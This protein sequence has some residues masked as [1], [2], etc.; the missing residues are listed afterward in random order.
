MS[1]YRKT[2]SEAMAEVEK[3]SEAGYLE[4]KM[5]PR[6]IQNI[7]RIWQFKTK[8][9]VTPAVIKMI[10]NM[11]PVTQGAIKDAGINLLSDIAEGRMSEIDAMRKAGASAAEI[12]KELKL[13]V[14]TVKAILGE[15]DGDS[16]QD[17]QD[18]KPPREKI[19]ENVEQ[20]AE[21]AKK[22]DKKKDDVAPDNDVP[23]EV[24]EEEEPAKEVEKLKKELEKSREQTVAVKQKAQTDA[25]KQAQR[26]RTAQ[27]KMVN[28]QTG[29]PLLQVGIAYKHLKQKMEKEKKEEEQKQRSDEIAKLGA[30]K[31]KLKEDELDMQDMTESAAGD[32]AKAMGLDYMKFGRYG[33]DG[34]VTHKSKGDSLVAVGKGDEPKSDKPKSKKPKAGKKSKPKEADDVKV[35]ARNFLRDLD[36]GNL[37]NED[38]D[39]IEIDFDDEFSFDPIIDKAREMGLDDEFMDDLED[40]GS[41]VAEMEPNK[42]Q[43]AFRDMIAKY[44]GKPA[45]DI[46]KMKIADKQME[47]FNKQEYS[48]NNLDQLANDLLPLGKTLV[49]MA[50]ANEVE[51]VRGS[52]MQNSMRGFKDEVLSTIQS[53][54]Q[55]SSVLMDVASEVNDEEI[56]RKL[57]DIAFEFEYCWDENGDHDSYTKSDSVTAGLEMAFDGIKDLQKLVKKKGNSPDTRKPKK[58]IGDMI[59][60]SFDYNDPSSIEDAIEFARESGES[61]V[62]EDLESIMAQ[63]EDDTPKNEIQMEIQDKVAELTN[64]PLKVKKNI[65]EFDKMSDMILDKI[66]G[67]GYDYEKQGNKVF[68]ELGN[69]IR[70]WGVEFRDMAASDPTKGSPGSSAG[71]G[72]KAFRPDVIESMTMYSDIFSEENDNFSSLLDNIKNK[73]RRDQLKDR[74]EELNQYAAYF[75]E[76]DGDE[77]EYKKEQVM[78]S[79]EDMQELISKIQSGL[80]LVSLNDNSEK[81]ESRLDYVGRILQEKKHRREDLN[82]D[83]EKTIKPI[84]K[85][86]KKS[87]S[88]HDK[89]AKSLEKAMKNEMK[90]D[91]AY[92]IGMAQAKKVMND[93]PPLQKKTIKKGHEIADKILKKEENLQE[94]LSSSQIAILKREYEPFRGKTI[95]AARARQLMNILDKFKE[96]DLKKLAKANIPFVSSGSESKLAVRKMGYKV[97]T[98][99]PMGSF[100]E[101]VSE[102]DIDEACWTGYKQVG[103]K[104]KGN[105]QVPNCVPE[106]IDPFMI[107][108]SKHGKHAGFEGGKT[109]QDIQKKAQELRKK[110]FTID[111]MG[112]NNPPVKKE[113]APSEA[114]I[115]RLKKQG[116]KPRKEQKD[117]PAAAVY[118]SIAAVKKKA[119]KSGM[120]YGV[121][122]KVYDRGMAAWRGG[123]RPGATQVQ[124]ALARVN[125][126]VTKSS[127]T[128]GGADKD[129]AKQVKGK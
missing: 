42:A 30:D 112:R 99:R 7:K 109:L 12:A 95:N 96:A 58:K 126:F 8:K 60:N 121:L 69:D 118:E 91:D 113:N 28:P 83:D 10:K 15:S 87:V 75:S 120:P 73:K 46:E 93:E 66:E 76:R 36:K 33:K 102:K 64:K 71:S 55:I 54:E 105:K 128:W 51:G 82:K 24:K 1:R 114:D 116:M 61:E 119:E 125:S 9:D 11:D 47:L 22:M 100:K 39:S 45:K 37:E 20:W 59:D 79:I 14:K 106:A 67:D 49:D 127:G 23:V 34:K 101:E 27:D 84:I 25:Q 123:H 85:Q 6:Q 56:Q 103:M 52:G 50:K 43:S 31:P 115:E 3:I 74:F 44:S 70:R 21:A 62:A 80:S 129:L 86:L 72:S 48:P 17:A 110:G 29:E 38:G 32:K 16:A 104:K 111:K 13:S 122:K 97:T 108:Y 81:N 78:A 18:I 63:I 98:F 77:W 2:M 57:E 89:Q 90:K 41:Y 117:H 65:E 19:K 107:S 4:P 92:A 53:T 26:A 5:N 40:V 68:G 35:K 124:W 94:G 88:A